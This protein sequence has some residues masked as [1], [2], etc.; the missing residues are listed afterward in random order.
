MGY[1]LGLAGLMINPDMKICLLFLAPA[2]QIVLSALRI[3]G[4]IS[5]PLV[6]GFVFAVIAG[7]ICAYLASQL[8]PVRR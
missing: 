8:A 1:H 5:L 6:G 3:C 4:R 7:F 2:L